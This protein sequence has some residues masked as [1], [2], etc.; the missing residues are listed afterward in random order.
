MYTY[1]RYSN[2][3]TELSYK[4][5]F[6]IVTYKPLPYNPYANKILYNWRWNYDY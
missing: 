3:K 6:I 2:N 1:L 4:V 5:Y